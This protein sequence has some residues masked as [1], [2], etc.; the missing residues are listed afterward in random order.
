MTWA[1]AAYTAVLGGLTLAYSPVAGWRRLTRGV[2]VHLSARFGFYDTAPAA[3]PSVWIHSVSVGETLAAVPLV[4]ALRRGHP[5]IPITVT[6]VTATGAHVAADRLASIATHRFFPLDLPGPV[7]RAIEANRPRCFIAIETELW[8]NLL[9]ALAR[10][11]VP[12]MIANGRVSDR[13]FRRYLRVRGLVR[14][15]LST[16]SVFAMR[17]AEDSRRIVAL[18]ADPDRVFVTGDLKT[19]EPEPDSRAGAR[20]RGL[21][22]IAPNARVWIAGSTHRGEEEAILDVHRLVCD[23]LGPLVL[24]VAPRHP[25]RAPEVLRAARARGH[26]AIRRSEFPRPRADAIVVLDTVGELAE[27]YHLADVVFVGGSLVPVGGHNVLEP[28]LRRKPVL[29]GPH[30]SNVREGAHVLLEHGGGITVANPRELETQLVRLLSDDRLRHQIGETAR[31]AVAA[32]RGATVE[33][34]RLIERYL[35]R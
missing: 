14:R 15:M 35:F 12:V 27:L 5:E 17:S 30:V 34:V 24:V 20:W 3:A 11:G 2:P 1:Y 18:G 26:S 19:D 10:R 21:L 28:A 6:T 9:R 7:A 13:S 33:T 8:P 16:V 23:R 29:F 22:D 4:L 25:E 32:R 31:E